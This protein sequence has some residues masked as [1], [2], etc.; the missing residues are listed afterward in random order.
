MPSKRPA[1]PAPFRDREAA[2]RALG[3][4]LAKLA[5]ARPVVAGLP[6]GG[7]VVAAGVSRRLGAPLTVVHARKLTTDVEPELAFGAV[8]EDGYAVFDS[9]IITVLGIGEPEIE[10]IRSRVV[11]EISQRRAL[12]RATP[13]SSLARDATVVLVDDG[14]ATGLTM[15]A[16]MA[17][18]RRAGAERSIVATPCASK[19]AA[20]EI[21][22]LLRRRGDRFVSLVVD[23]AF[24]AVG[25]YYVEF[26]GTSDSEVLEALRRAGAGSE[27]PG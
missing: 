9:R 15:K 14:L 23:P 2:A 27:V 18:A 3:D 10:A 25:D 17:Y 7:V 5:I 24:A 21:A 22:E 6:R 8:D 26:E 11:A 19:R 1:Q 16:A 12:Y 20:D 4:E 13:L